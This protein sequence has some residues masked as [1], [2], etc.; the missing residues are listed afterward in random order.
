MIYVTNFQKIIQN[1]R[2]IYMK[3]IRKRLILS[4]RKDLLIG[5]VLIDDNPWNGAKDFNGTWLHYGSN[6]Y[7]DWNSIMLYI[8]SQLNE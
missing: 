1:G 2:V 5:D 4:H 6:A 3:Q 8:A 7:P